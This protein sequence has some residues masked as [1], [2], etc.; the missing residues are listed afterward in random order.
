MAEPEPIG[1]GPR[2]DFS[3]NSKKCRTDEG[4]PV[5]EL[6]VKAT[7]CPVCGSKRITPLFNS[8]NVSK[9][10]FY[11]VNRI[12]DREGARQLSRE[13]DRRDAAIQ[14]QKRG[15]STFAVPL[16]TNG[17]IGPGIAKHMPAIAPAFQGLTVTPGASANEGM[18]VQRREIQ[19]RSLGADTVITH[20]DSTK[21]AKRPDGLVEARE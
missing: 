14:Q 15:T 18:R 13:H 9:S 17:A 2:R 4:A 5:Y 19:S 20:R 12:V 10:G 1:A 7:R 21:I 6:P 8:I 3:C 11:A 16:G